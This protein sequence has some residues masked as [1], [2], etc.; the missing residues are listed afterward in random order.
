[1]E[2]HHY[3]GFGV[4][5]GKGLRHLPVVA[6]QPCQLLGRGLRGAQRGQRLADFEAGLAAFEQPINVKNH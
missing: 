4:L 5:F 1:M 6:D 2:A 3:L